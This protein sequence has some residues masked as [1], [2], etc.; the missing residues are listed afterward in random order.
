MIDVIENIIE[1][2]SLLF[3]LEDYVDKYKL[4]LGDFGEEESKGYRTVGE[5]LVEE[6]K[7]PTNKSVYEWNKDK[8]NNIKTIIEES[9]NELFKLIN[10]KK[11]A[12]LLYEVVSD[13]N[14]TRSNNVIYTMNQLINHISLI[15]VR[16]TNDEVVK[17]GY[18]DD[19][20]DN[21]IV[22]N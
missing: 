20:S 7:M 8:I 9:R 15:Y 21:V 10:I 13:S 4:S 3:T 18:G 19:R 1:Y 17:V 14:I 5:L 11:K 6:Y 2:N 16:A 22:I 12:N